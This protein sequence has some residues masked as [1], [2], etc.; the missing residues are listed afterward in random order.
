MTTGKL[1]WY[2]INKIE[3]CRYAKVTDLFFIIC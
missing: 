2:N 1:P 3:F